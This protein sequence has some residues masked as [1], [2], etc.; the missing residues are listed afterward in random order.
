MNQ[1]GT[2]SES[3]RPIRWRGLRPA[4]AIFIEKASLYFDMSIGSWCW[5]WA[6]EHLQRNRVQGT[7]W[8]TNGFDHVGG[9]ILGN[10][11][12][13]KVEVVV[14][15]R[16][17]AIVCLLCGRG[18]VAQEGDCAYQNAAVLSVTGI[19]SI[20]FFQMKKKKRRF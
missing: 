1:R 14:L 8:D 2:K 5:C 7:E 12:D 10:E 20:S 6:R 9:V 4:M 11:V 15:V 17:R 19:F 3:D 16:P 13:R 18:C